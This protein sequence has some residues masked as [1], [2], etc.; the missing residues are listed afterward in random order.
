[1]THIHRAMSI[2]EASIVLDTLIEVYDRMKKVKKRS[3]DDAGYG[4]KREFNF[5]DASYIKV[6]LENNLEL[7]T[8]DEKLYK[9]AGRYIKTFKSDEF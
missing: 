2:D 9:I 5:Y 8:D 4:S 3:K 6:A 1:M 7:V